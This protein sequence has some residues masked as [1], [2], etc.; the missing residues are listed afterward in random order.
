MKNAQKLIKKSEKKLEKTIGKLNRASDRGFEIGIILL[1]SKFVKLADKHAQLLEQFE[2][3]GE[4][5]YFQLS[6]TS[7]GYDID[8]YV[9]NPLEDLTEDE[10]KKIFGEQLF[11]VKKLSFADEPEQSK[12]KFAF[13]EKEKV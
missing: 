6:T 12:E 1:R 10:N 13:N 9:K 11:P 5:V 4:K 3:D 8:F 7:K 2:T